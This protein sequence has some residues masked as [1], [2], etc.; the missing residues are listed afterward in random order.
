VT[1]VVPAGPDAVHAVV[2]DVTRV[3][4]RSPA[5]DPA[6]ASAFPRR[7]RAARR[8]PPRLHDQA[9]RHQFTARAAT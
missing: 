4:E 8:V 1:L 2:A 7:P 6:R 9:L 5:A 3:G